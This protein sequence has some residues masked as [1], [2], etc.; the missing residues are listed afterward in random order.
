MKRRTLPVAAALAATAALL[1]T[2]CGGGD[3]SSKGNDKIAGADGTGGSTSPSPSASTSASTEK[4]APSFDFPSDITVV[5]DRESTG[6]ATKDAV[7]R[8]LA[9]AAEARLEAFAKGNGQTAN[10]NRYFAGYARTYWI[11]RVAELKKQGLTV[12]GHYRYFDFE[13][14]D[15]ANSKTAAVRYCEDQSKAY[16]KVIKTQKVQVTKPS[17]KD[18]VLNTLQV[19]KDSAGDWQ[20]TRQSWKKGDASCVRG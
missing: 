6:D 5:V 16:G 8:D 15:I 2:A 12:T 10:L 7:L 4:N 3:D 1:L 11:G 18:F 20:V 17:D 19:A 13:V 9:Y 14:T